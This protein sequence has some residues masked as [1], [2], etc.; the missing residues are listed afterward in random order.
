MTLRPAWRHTNQVLFVGLGLLLGAAAHQ[1]WATALLVLLAGSMEYQAWRMATTLDLVGATLTA[2][3]EYR[4]WVIPVEDV[5]RVKA[6]RNQA[7]QLHL[8]EGRKIPILRSGALGPFLRLLPPPGPTMDD[9]LRRSLDKSERVDEKLARRR[10][11]HPWVRSAFVG[12]AFGGLAVMLGAFLLVET[13]RK[14][15]QAR[16]V[17]VKAPV[18]A[19]APHEDDDGDIGVTVRYESEAGTHL[20]TVDVEA[21]MA[22]EVGSTFVVAVD[23]DHPDVAWA[24]G[25][26]PIV[27][28]EAFLPL[29][30]AGALLST[31]AFAALAPTAF[32]EHPAPERL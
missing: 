2:R 20:R 24:P 16:A 12:C 18:V 28:P 25:R 6:S 22:P 4:T 1:W 32:A 9:R 8:T 30:L 15:V 10:D 21:E 14:Q 27:Y 31:L 7:V 11:R 23:P 13:N 17:A 26:H 3:G 5:V 29:V 19:I